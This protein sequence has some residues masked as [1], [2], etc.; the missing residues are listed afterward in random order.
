[1]SISDSEFFGR[2]FFSEYLW[3]EESPLP[4]V[5]RHFHAATS[6]ENIWLRRHLLIIKHAWFHLPGGASNPAAIP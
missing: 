1:M 2:L 4:L 5:K 6:V 3:Q